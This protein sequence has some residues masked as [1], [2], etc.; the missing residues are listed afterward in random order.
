[1]ENVKANRPLTF[2]DVKECL[3]IL[4]GAV[5]IVYPM[6]LPSYDPIRMEFENREEINPQA[7]Q[8]GTAVKYLSAIVGIL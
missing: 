3:E 6:G 5:N 1:M 8:V 4:K 2:A 7:N